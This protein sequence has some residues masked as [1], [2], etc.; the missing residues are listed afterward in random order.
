MF[1]PQKL[2]ALMVE[3]DEKVGHPSMADIDKKLT[4][5][6][7]E[8]AIL[9]PGN[10]D[11]SAL[12]Q[13][14]TWLVEPQ[15]T[16]EEFHYVIQPLFRFAQANMH[17]K[18]ILDDDSCL[19]LGKVVAEALA[20]R[21]PVLVGPWE[22]ALWCVVY[23]ISY[24]YK[25]EYGVSSER[26]TDWLVQMIGDS[27]LCPNPALRFELIHVL[28]QLVDFFPDPRKALESVMA[29]CAFL[30][31]DY[32]EEDGFQ[33]MNLESIINILEMI[34]NDKD[35]E[36]YEFDCELSKELLDTKALRLSNIVSCATY[37][38]PALN[39][40]ISSGSVTLNG[41]TALLKVICKGTSKLDDVEE[42]TKALRVI[43]SM[44]Q[45]TCQTPQLVELAS[46]CILKVIY[47]EAFI[48]KEWPAY[49][50][51]SDNT[52]RSTVL[53]IELL[54]QE[55]EV[56]RLPPHAWSI[57]QGLINLQHTS[58]FHRGMILYCKTELYKSDYL[59]DSIYPHLWNLFINIL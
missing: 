3:M 28:I 50:G 17:D 13:L 45:N 53:D 44:F 19:Y 36:I 58:L 8:L 42:T 35:F 39:P 25:D 26:L 30:K 15:R 40:I 6:L 46:S 10:Q 41:I 32:F 7:E 59:H 43:L 56:S 24:N 21:R 57:C 22:V 20:V 48:A 51:V 1:T 52:Y 2:N 27:S 14:Y 55:L 23:E 54:L 33:R 29:A 47:T 49:G 11:H 12:K 31:Y 5:I 38:Y 4:P 18:G 16:G 9:G 34:S 37:C